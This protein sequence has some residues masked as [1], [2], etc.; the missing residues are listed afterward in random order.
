MIGGIQLGP[1]AAATGGVVP[2]AASGAGDVAAS[3]E[4]A[5]WLLAGLGSTAA[6]GRARTPHDGDPGLPAPTA[7]TDDEDGTGSALVTGVALTLPPVVT[8]PL[9]TS[10][11]AG[12]D[13][14]SMSTPDPQFT[15]RSAPAASPEAPFGGGRSIAAR[16]DPT[17][18]ARSHDA[19]P[20]GAATVAA[21]LPTDDTIAPPAGEAVPPADVPDT[22]AASMVGA[23]RTSHLPSA[24]DATAAQ[25]RGSAGAGPGAHLPS[26]VTPAAS[27]ADSREPKAEA[28]ETL[29]AFEAIDAPEAA[30][31]I[32]VERLATPAAPATPATPA[33]PAASAP[34]ATPSWA[35]PAAR[36]N[37]GAS[38]LA[39]AALSTAPAPR[40]RQSG[41]PADGP[42]LTPA[43]TAAPLV[44][45]RPASNHADV[46]AAPV[47]PHRSLSVIAPSPRSR[48]GVFTD[49]AAPTGTDAASPLAATAAER[50][51]AVTAAVQRVL[52]ATTPSEPGLTADRRHLGETLAPAVLAATGAA[53]PRELPIGGL[54]VESPAAAGAAPLDEVLPTQIIRSIRLQWQA[55]LGEARVQLRPEY[56][57]EMTVAV[58]VEQG[59]VT[60]TLHAEAPE[61]RRWIEAHS[62]SLRDALAE[63][64]LRLDRLVVA[65]ERPRHDASA[66][67]RQ[68]QAPDDDDQA[69]RRRGRPQDGDP[70]F[71]FDDTDPHE[72]TYA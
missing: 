43:P 23:R 17:M 12:I 66:D 19:E 67:R 1:P 28:V 20:F 49:A 31:G 14:P 51:A 30:A 13:A 5:A 6:P 40:A 44:L 56:L 38:R 11:G 50:G 53:A 33:T 8:T 29:P 32:P 62:G 59:A 47:G 60:A 2:S 55:G 34:S 54:A 10:T 9:E 16:R 52:A 41:E 35:P 61:V 70:R 37:P 57:G 7:T 22:D 36:S 24:A 21:G 68:R 39:S 46:A 72:R 65:E 64:G 45:G 3:G 63:Q 27:Q 48:R 58:K 71:E 42:A 18:A 25:H 26:R 69:R 4:F 15:N